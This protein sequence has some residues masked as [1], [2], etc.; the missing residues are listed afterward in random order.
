M[1]KGC[2]AIPK[3]LFLP[4]IDMELSCEVASQL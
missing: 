3:H 2:Q 4:H 1:W